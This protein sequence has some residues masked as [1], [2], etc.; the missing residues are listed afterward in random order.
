MKRKKGINRT[1]EYTLKLPDGSTIQVTPEAEAEAA[2][3]TQIRQGAQTGA[4]AQ[5]EFVQG[6]PWQE[7]L[8]NAAKADAKYKGK[9]VQVTAKVSGIYPLTYGRFQVFLVKEKFLDEGSCSCWF[10]ANS[11]ALQ[12]LDKGDLVTV[13]GLCQEYRYHNLELRHCKIVARGG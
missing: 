5:A 6:D 8:D 4:I 12:D 2:R 9:R 3:Q 11:P 7:Y 1:I 10:E 13:E